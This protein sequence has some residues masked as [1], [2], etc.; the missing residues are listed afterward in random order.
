V[1]FFCCYLG[2]DGVL[3]L[4]LSW[5]AKT[6]RTSVICHRNAIFLRQRGFDILAT[7]HWVSLGG[8]LPW[9]LGRDGT[10]PGEAEA[11]CLRR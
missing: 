6:Q 11:W 8:R 4:F 10:G 1:D 3:S 5:M 9:E 2:P 7:R